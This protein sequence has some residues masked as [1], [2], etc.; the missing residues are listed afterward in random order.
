MYAI[1]DINAIEQ[2]TTDNAIFINTELKLLSEIQQLNI[3]KQNITEL[4]KHKLH[5]KGFHHCINS[6]NPNKDKDV[7]SHAEKEF[8][9]LAIKEGFNFL[10]EH[11]VKV[12]DIKG[13]THTYSLDFYDA[14]RKANI[15]INPLFHYTYET[16]RKRDILR[17]LLLKKK[18]HIKT[19]HVLAYYNVKAKRCEI[20]RE[21]ALKVLKEVK[22]LKVNRESL[23][24]YFKCTKKSTK[25]Y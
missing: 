17:I 6:H 20:D 24:Y 3:E 25:V 5:K 9:D 10:H 19:F 2:L 14:L 8:Y 23:I 13:I 16:V 12:K 4:N 1:T 21:Q 18:R 11:K 7:F 15:E 22:K